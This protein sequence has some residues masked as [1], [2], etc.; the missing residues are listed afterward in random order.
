MRPLKGSSCMWEA[1]KRTRSSETGS[2]VDARDCKSG[3]PKRYRARGTAE[4]LSL[5]ARK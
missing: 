4:I 1:P 3:K 5:E 2:K